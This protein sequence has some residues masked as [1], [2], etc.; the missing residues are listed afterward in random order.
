M[1][2][3]IWDLDDT[4][5]KSPPQFADRCYEIAARLALSHGY[6]GTLDDANQ[7]ARR[8]FSLHGHAVT[9]FFLEH[10]LDQNV[11]LLGFADAIS[12][13]VTPCDD[14]H[15]FISTFSG[16]QMVMSH[17]AR[18]WVDAMMR[19]L[20]LDP[21]IGATH[22]FASDDIGHSGKAQSTLPFE[23]AALLLGHEPRDVIVFEDS[24][25][26]LVHAKSLGMTTILVTNG[27]TLSQDERQTLHHVDHI[28]AR[29]YEFMD[30]IAL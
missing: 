11:M 13:L 27:R 16:P 17:S 18:S 19:R 30:I 15:R 7:E 23:K 4:I 3:I 22:R 14:T 6:T 9:T 10:H 2:A 26:N 29:P 1:K 25:L 12:N 20:G 21:L 5:Y 28:I 24:A 8:S